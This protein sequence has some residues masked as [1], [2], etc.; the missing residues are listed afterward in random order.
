VLALALYAVH[1]AYH[2]R[3][4]HPEH[5]LWACHLAA[6]FVGVGLLRASP[7]L[8]AIGFLW[9]VIGNALW[10]LDLAGG[11]EFIPTSRGTH[12]GGLALSL[13]ALAR[14]GMPR[15]AWWQAAAV[16]LLLQQ[17]TRWLSPAGANVNVA[18]RVWDG[19]EGHF[20]SYPWDM[21]GLVASA[22][23]S[24]SLTKNDRCCAP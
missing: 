4:G 1:A 3:D 6:V 20:P 24:A 9:L 7:R 23:A 16:F 13:I 19:W 18:F 14:L 10:L 5:L 21:A 8:N 2:L 11:G 22:L 15:H 17:L 12:V